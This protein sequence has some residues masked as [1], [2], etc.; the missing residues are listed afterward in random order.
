M[1]SD[2]TARDLIARL[3]SVDPDTPVRLAINPSFPLEHT[4]ADVLATTD[5]L[6][7]AVLYVV[8]SGQQVGPVPPAVTVGAGW[9][10]P[11]EAPRCRRGAVAAH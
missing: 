7:N 6:G 1:S 10:E 2:F 9:H 11:T 4:V 8:E 3:S 5:A